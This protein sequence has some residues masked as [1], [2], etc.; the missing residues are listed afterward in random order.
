MPLPKVVIEDGATL[1]DKGAVQEVFDWAKARVTHSASFEALWKTLRIKLLEG[2]RRS[3]VAYWRTFAEAYDPPA[4][5]EADKNQA[6]LQRSGITS[7][8]S[9]QL[10][11]AATVYGGLVAQLVIVGKEAAPADAEAY[12]TIAA[13]YAT[14]FE[15]AA[16]KLGV[17]LP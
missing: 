12:F 3:A 14:H 13:F 2:N 8:T 11:I 6:L 7:L 9:R 17:S 4:P 5:L 10:Q 15:D 1:I 16:R